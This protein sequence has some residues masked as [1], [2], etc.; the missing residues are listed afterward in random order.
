[1]A[2]KT[3]TTGEVLTSTDT[4]TYLTNAGL[5]Y[6]K[7]QTIGTGVPSVTVPSAFTP[8]YD[9]YQVIYEMGDGSNP[10]AAMLVTF[11]NSA[12]A[13]YSYGGIYVTYGTA[14]VTAETANNVTNGIRV[15]NENAGL[16]S[17]V[18]EIISPYKTTPTHVVAQHADQEYW[19]TRGGRDSNV[20]SHTGFTLTPSAGTLTGGTIYVYGYR[21]A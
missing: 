5:V 19:S 18:F 2:I 21:K 14:T 6:I 10:A 11:N 16:S 7:Q 8:T 9:N 17:I 13:T 3:F 15:G 1:M 20:V 12:G 4:N